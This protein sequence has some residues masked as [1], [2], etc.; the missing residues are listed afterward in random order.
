M[1][2]IASTTI[3]DSDRF[4]ITPETIQTRTEIKWFDG[5]NMYKIAVLTVTHNPGYPAPTISLQAAIPNIPVRV[6][7]KHDNVVYSD[8]NS[9]KQLQDKE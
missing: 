9:N 2:I 7:D 4:W 6:Y 3:P 1:T 8:R 5:Q